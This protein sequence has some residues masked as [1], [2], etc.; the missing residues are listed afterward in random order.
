MPNGEALILH[1]WYTCKPFYRIFFYLPFLTASTFDVDMFICG[2]FVRR[3]TPLN[4]GFF[5]RNTI[6]RTHEKHT[7]SQLIVTRRQTVIQSL[8][9]H[10]VNL[11]KHRT[12]LIYRHYPQ[13]PLRTYLKTHHKQACHLHKTEIANHIF[14]VN[15]QPQTANKP[16]FQTVSLIST[17]SNDIQKHRKHTTKKTREC[18]TEK[19]R[20][21]IVHSKTQNYCETAKFLQKN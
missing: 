16:A 1:I 13:N 14:N 11:Q 20:I 4:R 15:K 21:F 3:G 5:G 6:A 10:I 7:L 17:H 2:N 18:R 8:C 9:H 19:Q 12:R